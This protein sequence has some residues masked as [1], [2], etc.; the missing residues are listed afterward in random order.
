MEE[1]HGPGGR[2]K[3]PNKK[4]PPGRK[5]RKASKNPV[6]KFGQLLKEIDS[7][8]ERIVVLR[9]QVG[10]QVQNIG[11]GGETELFK[12]IYEASKSVRDSVL[13]L[14]ISAFP[15]MYDVLE[16]Y[17]IILSDAFHVLDEDQIANDLYE[18]LIYRI[19]WCMDEYQ[20]KLCQSNS[21]FGTYDAS[22]PHTMFHARSILVT[23]GSFFQ[24]VQDKGLQEKCNKITRLLYLQV[25]LLL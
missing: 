11:H 7:A 22:S 25:V 9:K 16:K 4:I 5:K 24:A 20:N 12:R 17:S 23:G 13:S 3:D 21:S 8:T 15:G 19:E 6:I 14:P 18:A 2:F 10:V 1:E